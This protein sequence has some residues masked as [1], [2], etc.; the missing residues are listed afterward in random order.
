MFGLSTGSLFIFHVYLSLFNRTTLGTDTIS[1]CSLANIQI[2]IYFREY[3]V[4]SH[5]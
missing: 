4:A 2:I 5:G 1:Y 3:A